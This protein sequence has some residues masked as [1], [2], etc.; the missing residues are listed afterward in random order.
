VLGI[1]THREEKT[2]EP[3]QKTAGQQEK[4]KGEGKP[5]GQ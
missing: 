2:E 4:T 1:S 3:G 5:A